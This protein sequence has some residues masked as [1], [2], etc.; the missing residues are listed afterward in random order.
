MGT[1]RL[2]SFN[3]VSTNNTLHTMRGLAV[4]A[5]L[6]VTSCVLR[7]VSAACGAGYT[8]CHEQCGCALPNAVCCEDKQHCC[9]SGYSCDNNGFCIS[10]K[11]A[12]TMT[13]PV[14]EEAEELQSAS[15]VSLMERLLMKRILQ[16][17][18]NTEE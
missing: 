15:K 5:V 17:L 10:K 11:R 14:D 9:P 12:F 4:L 6:L 3:R 8:E 2:F 7:D 1:F 18:E 13:S 16:K